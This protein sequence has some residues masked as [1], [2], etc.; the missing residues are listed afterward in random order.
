ME[1][2]L[3]S[4]MC[5]TLLTCCTINSNAQAN[6]TLSNLTSPTAVNQSLLPG[7]TNSINLGST[8]LRWKNIHLGNA[9]YLKG[10]LSLHAPGTTN[11]FAGGFAGNVLVTGNSNTG[12]GQNALN[13]LT[14]GSANTANGSN[15][16]YS[17]TTGYA[18]TA[19]GSSSLYYNS[20]GRGNTATGTASLYR[21]TSGYSNTAAGT[22]SLYSN[23]TG[24]GNT[25]SGYYS[26]YSN[27]TGYD[28]TAMGYEALFKNTIGVKNTACGF[29]ALYNNTTG[30]YNTAIGYQALFKNTTGD[31]N[32]A[33]GFN[34]L[35]N[36]TT[37]LYNTATGYYALYWNIGELNTANGYYALYS[38][39]TGGANTAI[40]LKALYS[41][42]TGYQNNANGYYSLYKN[43]AGSFNTGTGNFALY[44]NTT[45]E[46]NTAIGY[47]AGSNND[48]NTSCTFVGY[49]ADQSVSTD[50]AN[51]TALGK[52]SRITA[53][54]QVRIGNS[55]VT[56]IGGYEPWTNLSDG[57]FKKN[58]KKD[59]PGLA[60][61]SQ[62]NAITYT[63]DVRSLR[64]FLG[65]DRR[66]KA[67]GETV[68]EKN[69]EA[70]ASIQ[71]EIEEKEMIIR[72]GF[73]AQEVEAAAKKIGYSFSGV[74]K[75]KNE[76]T[77]YGLRYSEF[78]VPL[79]KAVQE[80]SAKND[81]LQKQID[82]LKA[83]VLKNN[84][85]TTLHVSS[86]TLEQ[87]V[88]NPFTN[89]TTIHY[90][91]PGKPVSAKIIITDKSGKSLKELNISASG[92]GS[93]NI[94]AATLLSG[95]YQYSLI[96][97]GKVIDTKQMV[98][99]E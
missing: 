50:F 63:M 19:T 6:K 47:Y 2:K 13:R 25:A 15:S 51:S 89:S 33:L 10:I 4:L 71:K 11:F 76:H 17:N 32:T 57:R 20:T 16:M 35:Y 43:T 91:L 78:V 95:A 14:S 84:P 40:G 42:T 56:S 41:S 52:T 82:E 49:D 53:S 86:A 45:G 18:N 48:N 98:L 74:D 23:T 37:G 58:V 88:P 70:E 3:L 8:S 26:M 29:A 81:E 97:D 64:S 77:P 80:L 72:T 54:N 34:A 7:T 67:E 12:I 36:N 21:N 31:V 85:E 68:R 69:F 62:L 60:F 24:Y 73:V 79:V 94:N 5:Y 22:N 1:T 38:N 27:T 55:S 39:I 92:R 87:N 75:P 90:T 65:E 9:L 46:F 66:N 96:I 99:A 44:S 83:I 30:V 93:I 59:V 28:N 61:I